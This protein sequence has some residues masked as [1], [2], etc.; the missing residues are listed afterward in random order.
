MRVMETCPFKE[1][2]CNCGKLLFKGVLI[3][4]VVEIKCLRCRAINTLH[5]LSQISF[6]VRDS[7]GANYLNSVSQFK[8]TEISA[9]HESESPAIITLIS[10]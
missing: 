1:F 8:V 3:A 2:R 9:Q 7:S 6:V 4:S 10:S 5:G